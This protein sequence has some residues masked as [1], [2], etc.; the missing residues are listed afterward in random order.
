MRRLIFT[1]LAVLCC[2]FLAEVPCIAASPSSKEADALY[3]ELLKDK[4]YKEADGKMA[5]AY[6][7]LM[8]GLDAEGQQKLR[9]EQRDWI[10]RRDTLLVNSKCSVTKRCGV[11]RLVRCQIWHLRIR[12]SYSLG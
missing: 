2:V 5:A 11:K 10:R 3:N 6:T 4:S 1:V 7:K 9:Q 8:R 12:R